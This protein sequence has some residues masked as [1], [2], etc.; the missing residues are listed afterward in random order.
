M[1]AQSHLGPTAAQQR[2]LAPCGSPWP[3]RRPVVPSASA[4]CF[5]FGV[6]VRKFHHLTLN[7]ALDAVETV[8]FQCF[9]NK[10]YSQL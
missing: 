9:V 6:T 7:Q 2:S 10:N 5:G 1:G 3:K 8:D 4:M